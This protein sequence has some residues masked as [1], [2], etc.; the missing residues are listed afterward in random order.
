[1]VRTVK[2]NIRKTVFNLNIYLIFLR[3][4]PLSSKSKSFQ[5]FSPM[6]RTRPYRICIRRQVAFAAFCPFLIACQRV[7]MFFD[8]LRDFRGKS[9]FFC[10]GDRRDMAGYFSLRL[11]ARALRDKAEAMQGRLRREHSRPEQMRPKGQLSK[12]SFFL[13]TK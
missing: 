8:T 4:I 2:T 1:M 7:K 10:G 11:S 5:R 3:R 13:F 6:P 12:I 9:L